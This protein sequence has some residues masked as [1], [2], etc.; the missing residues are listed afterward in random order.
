M[1]KQHGFYMDTTWLADL[2]ALS[3]TLN[4]SRAAQIRNITQPAFGRR[5]RALEAWCG[6][7]LVERGSHRLSLTP[8]GTVMLDAAGDVLRR[9]DR[10]RDDIDQART[11]TLTFAATH[12]LSFTFFPAWIK[13]LGTGAAT[14][15]MR[16]LSDNMIRCE[17]MMQA[18]EA[19]F[20]LCHHH[21]ASPTCLPDAGFDHVVLARDRLVPVTGRDGAG[22]PLH[23]LPGTPARPVPHI[24]F[25]PSSGMGRILAAALPSCDGPLHLSPLFSS[26]LAMAVK[27]LAIEGKGV[28]WIPDSLARDELGPGGRLAGGGDG[29]HVDVDIALFRPS[30]PLGARAE[31]FWQQLGEAASVRAAANH[32]NAL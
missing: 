8:A 7:S 17:R 1:P 14:Q 32:P 27:A 16:L 15:P 5:I 4:F 24:A 30:A 28:G 13:G 10:A 9:L 18:G 31:R 20:L 3:E 19:Q 23:R 22:R 26:H 25:E 2:K 11:A 6:V 21:V 12:A 29:W